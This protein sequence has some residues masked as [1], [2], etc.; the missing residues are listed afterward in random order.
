MCST[1]RVQGR[2]GIW[3]WVEGVASPSE[4][5]DPSRATEAQVVRPVSTVDAE[6]WP[7]HHKEDN[8][9]LGG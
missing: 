3:D 9:D 2:V 1:S 8:E 4:Q 6:A 5:G 7:E